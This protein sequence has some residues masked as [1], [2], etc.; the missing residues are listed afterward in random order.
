MAWLTD[1][2]L[3]QALET[4]EVL[5]DTSASPTVPAERRHKFN[6]RTTGIDGLCFDSKAEAKR[7]QQLLTLERAGEISELTLKPLYVL[8]PS[9]TDAYGEH[10]RAITYTADFA[11]VRNGQAVTEDVKGGKATQTQQFSIRWKLAIKQNPSIKFEIVI[12]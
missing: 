8:Q 7:Y 5:Y 1:K 9:F 11:Y 3:K 2:E 6:A 4:H 10:H 12:M